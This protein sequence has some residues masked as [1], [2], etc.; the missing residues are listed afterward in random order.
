MDSEEQFS[1]KAIRFIGWVDRH[2]IQ[3]VAVAVVVLGLAAIWGYSQWKQGRQEKK[4]SE[5]LLALEAS[6]LSAAQQQTNVTSTEYLEIAEQ[7]PSTQAGWRARLLGA[8]ELFVAGEYEKAQAAFEAVL[9]KT[10]TGIL[11]AQA[12]YGVAATLEAQGETEA[13]TKRYQQ[14]IDRFPDSSVAP[15]AKFSLARLKERQSH[16]EEALALYDEVTEVSSGG[17]NYWASQARQRRQALLD[18]HPELAQT[19]EVSSATSTNLSI[20]NPPPMQSEP[21]D[22]GAQGAKPA[23]SATDS[24][25]GGSGQ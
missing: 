19:N 21:A 24:S 11:A 9:A 12:G 16:P 14:V 6:D 8:K 10:S 22:S 4:A 20:P 17:A 7:Y 5:E 23:P 1:E 3:T 13:A 25:D 15:Q 2:R 18:E